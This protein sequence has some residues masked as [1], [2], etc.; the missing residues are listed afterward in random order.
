MSANGELTVAM[1]PL[2]RELERVT[3]ELLPGY[4]VEAKLTT[5]LL[6][7]GSNMIA[8]RFTKITADTP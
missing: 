8:V 1:P 6:A 2:C 7:G 4:V 3:R 5:P